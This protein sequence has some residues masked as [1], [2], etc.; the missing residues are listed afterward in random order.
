MTFGRPTQSETYGSALRERR[1]LNRDELPES[2]RLTR[3]A[4]KTWLCIF[5]SGLERSSIRATSLGLRAS[6]PH[7]GEFALHKRVSA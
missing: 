1:D 7:C 6:C 5:R 4:A 3:G 2:L